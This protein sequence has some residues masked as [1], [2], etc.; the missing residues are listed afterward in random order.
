MPTLKTI[1]IKL[2]DHGRIAAMILTFSPGF[3]ML[4]EFPH[5]V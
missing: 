3:S 5:F 1:G 4:N 2:E